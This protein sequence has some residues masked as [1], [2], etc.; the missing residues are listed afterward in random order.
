MD[1]NCCVNYFLVK[2]ARDFSGFQMERLLKRRNLQLRLDEVVKEIGKNSDPELVLS[3]GEVVQSQRMVSDSSTRYVLIK[4]ALEKSPVKKT[5]PESAQKQIEIVTI[6][7]E[8]NNE[9]LFA[10]EEDGLTQ[11]ELL[12]IM[13]S[14]KPTNCNKSTS[15]SSE[16]DLNLE[17]VPQP[18]P[19]SLH[20]NPD[21]SYSSEEDIFADVFS[22]TRALRENAILN[23]DLGFKEIVNADTSYKKAL[24]SSHASAGNIAIVDINNS[25]ERSQ[26]PL[27]EIEQ[28]SVPAASFSSKFD[29][30]QMS[31]G[32][33]DSDLVEVS[34]HEET[35][36]PK[37]VE[38]VLSDIEEIQIEDNAKSEEEVS[39]QKKP[40]LD[41]PQTESIRQEV[42]Q[43]RAAV[44]HEELDPPMEIW[45]DSDSDVSVRVEESSAAV[46]MTEENRADMSSQRKEE[47]EELGRHISAEQERLIQQHG[48]QERLAA[49]ITD[50]MYAESQVCLSKKLKWRLVCSPLIPCCSIFSFRNFYDCLGYRELMFIIIYSYF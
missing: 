38:E 49:S 23:Q 50:Q 24:I 48:K 31:S 22:P 46:A 27:K 45:D 41:K 6:E 15:S 44:S 33:D 26:V 35:V 11:Q 17:E 30:S 29:A 1:D 3:S 39:L 2:E 14:Q 32:S 19:L 12:T 18:A 16:D 47:L 34:L 9:D 43:I 42:F 4:K 21:Q 37:S 40:N 8:V 25:S 13:E 36:Q 10:L 20:V 5:P 28:K 7:N